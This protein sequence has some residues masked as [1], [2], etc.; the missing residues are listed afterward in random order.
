MKYFIVSDIHGHYKE[1]K[2]AL[3]DAH[4]NPY[5]ERHTLIVLGDMFDRGGESRKVYKFIK[6]LCDKGYAYVV[7]GNHEK[8]LIDYLDGTS[9]NPFNYL[10]NGTKETF[11]DFLRS[12]SAFE[13]WCIEHEEVPTFGAFARWLKE[14][15]EQ[16]NKDYPELLSWLKS[17]P[18][19]W[20]NDKYIGVHGG[21]DTKAADWHKPH[22]VRY[23]LTDWDA[24]EFDDGS[25]F[26]KAILN[27]DKTVIIGHFGTGHLRS[28]YGLG[29]KD[30][31]SILRRDDGRVI[32]IDGCVAKT[33]N[34]NVLTVSDNED[35]FG[36]DTI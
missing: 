11:D 14:A 8:F 9:V 12:T 18:R 32:A 36:E 29:D 24:L 31:F 16:I 5:K 25:F 35:D 26:S 21:I 28:M 20:E 6:N 22:C 1:L 15:R 17:L 7:R 34:V 10:N 30:D 3:V 4:F 27:T 13:F 2:Q 33:K 23:N 19:Y